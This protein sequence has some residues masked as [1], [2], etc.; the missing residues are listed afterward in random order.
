MIRSST[1]DEN[2]KKQHF[3]MKRAQ[4]ERQ[5]ADRDR[6]FRDQAAAADQESLQQIAVI[7]EVEPKTSPPPEPP[8]VTPPVQPPLQPPKKT[9]PQPAPQ[10]APP[11]T[12]RKQT[13]SG[14]LVRRPEK[15]HI[16]VHWSCFTAATSEKSDNTGEGSC[17]SASKKAKV[18]DMVKGENVNTGEHNGAAAGFKKTVEK[19]MRGFDLFK[20]V[21]YRIWTTAADTETKIAACSLLWKNITESPAWNAFF[22]KFVKDFNDNN[23]GITDA[24]K[25]TTLQN[26]LIIDLAGNANVQKFVG[27]CVFIYTEETETTP[28]EWNAEIPENTKRGLP[29]KVGEDGKVVPE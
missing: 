1:M 4:L 13:Q 17:G 27:M 26:P 3:A 23:P 6:V 12:Y 21:C 29:P 11:P 18:V 8:H 14:G 20:S 22:K 19:K 15:Y 2:F 5:A 10:P 28:G 16:E 7:A 9:A 25:W 24:K